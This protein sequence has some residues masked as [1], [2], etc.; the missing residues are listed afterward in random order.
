MDLAFETFSPGE[1]T[2]TVANHEMVHFVTAEVANGDTK[3][4]TG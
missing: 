2:Y 4:A 3:A 1:R